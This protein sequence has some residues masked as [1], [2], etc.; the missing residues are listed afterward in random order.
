MPL[1]RLMT[2]LVIFLLCLLLITLYSPK[3]VYHFFD[4]KHRVNL[5]TGSSEYY[6]D[7]SWDKGWHKL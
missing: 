2:I 4:S 1:D 3:Q 7:Q 6:S 5:V